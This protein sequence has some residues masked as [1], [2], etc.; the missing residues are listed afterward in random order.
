[1][2]DSQRTSHT[3]KGLIPARIVIGV[4]G[5]RRLADE[6]ALAKRVRE[7]LQRIEERLPRLTHTPIVFTILS[8]I[9]EGADRLVVHEVLNLDDAKRP[10]LEVALPLKK[11][12]YEKDFET[13]E[14]KQEF[15][16]LLSRAHRVV[17]LPYTRNRNEAYEQVGRYVVDHCDVLIALWNG[18]PA[19]GRGGTAEIVDYARRSGCPLFWINTENKP[20]EITEDNTNILKEFPLRGLDEYNNEST[21]DSLLR[22]EG[23]RWETSLLQTGGNVGLF[24]TVL[25]AIC[26]WLMPYYTRADQLALHNQRQYIKWSDAVFS[27]AVAAVAVV[28]FQTIFSPGWPEIV[29]GE[30]ALMVAVLCILWTIRQMKWQRKWIDYRFLAERLRSLLFLSLSGVHVNAPR[31]SRRAASP[32]YSQS[33]WVHVAFYSVLSEFPGSSNNHPLGALKNF[34]IEAW[35]RDQIKFH[36][37]AHERKTLQHHRLENAGLA[38]FGITIAV[39]IPHFLGVLP[40]PYDGVL[41]FLEIVLPTSAAALG[42]IRNHRDYLRYARHSDDMAAKLQNI[43]RK[44]IGAGDVKEL[45][46]FVQVTG[47]TMLREVEDWR[48]VTSTMKVGV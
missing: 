8:P 13:D 36:T 32:Y 41:T 31:P 27:L 42:A 19:A 7:T 39:A 14:S 44:L 40:D 26:N 34:L 22:R 12:D 4:T 20:Y 11:T 5:H 18:K 21:S 37:R 29:T 30:I 15:E 3:S 1:M 43:E 23:A 28:A 33:D 47:E 24:L 25:R 9:A 2:S 10:Q 17:D 38:L 35:V 48:I 16:R 6:S 46:Q 45:R